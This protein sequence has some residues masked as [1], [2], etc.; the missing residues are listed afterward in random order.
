MKSDLN[1]NE[2]AVIVEC[3][4]GYRTDVYGQPDLDMWHDEG[5]TFPDCPVCSSTLVKAERQYIE[6][7]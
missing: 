3:K 6:L 4:C 7:E 2:Y 5:L 1:L